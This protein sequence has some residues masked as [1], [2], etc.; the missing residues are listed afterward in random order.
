[1]RIEWDFV[2]SLITAV[3]ATIAIIQTGQQIRLSNKQHLFNKRTECYLIAIG[4]I[5]LYRNNC[6]RY[7]FEKDEP[8]FA[9]DLE[10]KW[11]TNNTYLEEI[12]CVIEKPLSEPGHKEFLIKVEEVKNIASKIE[13][14]FS[15]KPSV[16]LRDFVLFYQELLFSMY[17]YQIL[18]IN[19]KKRSQGKTLEEAQQLVNEKEYRENLLK[20]FENLKQADIK[21]KE[22]NVEEKLKKQIKL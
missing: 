22:E 20:A 13:F 10:F 3:V 2:F 15:G 8:L 16:A 4:L 1:M 17:Q 6:S 11:L 14:L 19:M 9:I 5:Q 7:V 12:S 18:L 21:L